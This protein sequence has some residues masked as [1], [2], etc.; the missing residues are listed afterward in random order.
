MTRPALDVGFSG[1]RHGMTH[2]Q[3]AHYYQILNTTPIRTL[4]QG[5]CTGADRQAY[6][7][8]YYLRKQITIH[9]WPPTKPDWE[10]H[11]WPQ[12]TDIMHA[13]LDYHDRDRE[14]VH[15]SGLL[16]ATPKSLKDKSGGTWYTISY[17]QAQEVPVLLIKPSGA[18]NYI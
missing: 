14:I 3:L 7:G 10:A 5:C 1:S 16:I 6:M 8:A 17:A 18:W 11:D 13:H 4:H 9:S 12:Y 15:N 2:E